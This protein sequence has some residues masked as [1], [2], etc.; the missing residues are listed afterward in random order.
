[1]F[2]L[3]SGSCSLLLL[4]QEGIYV[5]RDR[6]G[7]F[8]LI[9]G[10]R[11]GDWAVTT[12]TAAFHNLGYKITKYLRPAE[13]VLINKSGVKVKDKGNGINQT[14]AFLW[15]YTGFPASSY[16]GINTEIVREN[17]GRALARRD[18]VSVDVVSGIP[19]SGISHA[20]GY[21]MESGVPYRRV[22][23]KYTPG[24][25]RSY[26]PPSQEIRDL[27]AKMKLIPVEDIIK[28]KRVVICDDSIVRGTQFKN[29]T[30]KK[31]KEC[32]VKEIHLRIACPPLMFPC[33]FNFST[34]SSHELAAR[35]AIQ[36][37]EGKDI[38]NVKDYIDENSAKHKK[39]VE[40]IRKDLGATS[41]KYQ[42]LDDMVAAIGLP[43]EKLC[44]Y[45]WTGRQP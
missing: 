45:C 9:L 28:G 34:R 21:A 24:Y 33:K 18:N 36:A 19:D 30:I 43:K 7:Y 16:E 15:I 40:W 44:L 42:K 14:C 39:M 41:L 22:L 11:N 32:G 2:R 4:T 38:K 29:F 10:E 12:E 6:Y 35:R 26:T 23:I 8:P 13:I 25:G 17:S 1:M 3:I 27:V 5:A 20:I 31:L 37:L